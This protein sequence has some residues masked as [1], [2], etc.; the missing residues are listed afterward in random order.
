ML[1]DPAAVTGEIRWIDMTSRDTIGGPRSGEDRSS[2]PIAALG[3][4]GLFEDS[5]S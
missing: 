4:H 3:L 5:R 1:S 2:E